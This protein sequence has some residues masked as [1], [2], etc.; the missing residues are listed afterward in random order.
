M[1]NYCDLLGKSLVTRAIAFNFTVHKMPIVTNNWDV[2]TYENKL[3][4]KL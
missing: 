1:A 4:T 2:E 3:D